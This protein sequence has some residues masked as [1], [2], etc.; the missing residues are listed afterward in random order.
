[1]ANMRWTTEQYAEYQR[2]AAEE[3][4]LATARARPARSDAALGRT[5]AGRMNKT[6]ARYAQQLEVERLA[7]VIRW[8]GFEAITV[9]LADGCRLTPDFAVE[10]VDGRLQLREVKGSLR[11]IRDDARVKLKVAAEYLP[12]PVYLVVPQKGGGWIVDRIGGRA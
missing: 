1:M 9:R 6:E 3:A 5:K 2:R 4:R 7:G 10:D 12:W 8:W 11:M